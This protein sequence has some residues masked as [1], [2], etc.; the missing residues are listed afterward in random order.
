MTWLVSTRL[1]RA[2][3]AL[4]ALLAAGL[5]VFAAG[6]RNGRRDAARD[7][8]RRYRETRQEMD[9]A[10]VARGDAAADLDWLRD[11]AGR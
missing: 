11:R 9:D 5:A 1:G 2:L 3:A 8:L 10:D 6:W 4:G 7:E